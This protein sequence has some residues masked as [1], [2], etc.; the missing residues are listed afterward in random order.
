M[1]EIVDLEQ[2][3]SVDLGIDLRGRQRGVAQQ[4]LNLPQTGAGR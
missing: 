2:A 3:V 4:L 1:G